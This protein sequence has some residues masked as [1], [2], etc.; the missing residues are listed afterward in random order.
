MRRLLV[1]SL[2]MVI[3]WLAYVPPA[4]AHRLDEYLQATRVAID[5]DRVT[6][7]IDLTAGTSV[8]AKVFGWID[9]DGDGHLSSSERT[10]YAQQVIESVSLAADGRPLRLNLIDSDFP[11]LGEMADG[12][13]TIRLR[14]N[15]KLTAAASGRHMLT[16]LNSHH[17]EASVYLANALVPADDRIT[18]ANQRRDPAQHLLT[19]EYEVAYGAWPPLLLLAS[20]LA[21]VGFRSGAY[22]RFLPGRAA[23]RDLMR[24]SAPS[25]GA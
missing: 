5:V 3:A 10:A 2:G 11:E 9:T 1:G 17:S 22:S 25:S 13:G 7:E 15:A 14:A 12:T 6:L 23:R 8:A 24:T 18:I 4:E 20:M 16:Y 21:I 19:L